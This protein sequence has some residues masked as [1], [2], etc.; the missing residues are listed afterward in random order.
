MTGKPAVIGACGSAANFAED[1][2]AN[3][4]LKTHFA[5]AARVL[6]HLLVSLK[7]FAFAPDILPSKPVKGLDPELVNVKVFASLVV[8]AVCGS[9]VNASELSNTVDFR[10]IEPASTG[11][12]ETF[13]TSNSAASASPDPSP[14]FF[15]KSSSAAL[16]VNTA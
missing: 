2:G 13:L 8:F 5:P 11:L 9:N 7:F 1:V 15:F 4:K 16:I 6:P 3:V 10:L 14:L 12:P